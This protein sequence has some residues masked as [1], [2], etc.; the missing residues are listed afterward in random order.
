MATIGPENETVLRAA[1]G[2]GAAF[3]ELVDCWSGR[4]KA[5]AWRMTGDSN[6]AEDL[7]QDV[8]LHLFQVLRRFDGQRPFAPWMRRV[9]TNVILNRLRGKKL[10][11]TRLDAGT[12]GRTIALPDPLGLDPAAAAQR[13]E[14]IGRVHRAMRDLP[15]TWRAAVALRYSEGLSIAEIADALDVPPNT[16]KTRLFRAREALRAALRVDGARRGRDA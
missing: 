5:F 6:L 11:T 15:D 16:V 9:M 14:E 10:P 2:D 7:A 4:V 1:A 13:S 3:R 12:D 8:F